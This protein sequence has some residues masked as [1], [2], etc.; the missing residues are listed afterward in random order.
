MS[1]F[2]RGKKVR[3]KKYPMPGGMGYGVRGVDAYAVL[4]SY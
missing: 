1:N 2:P 3:A 4:T